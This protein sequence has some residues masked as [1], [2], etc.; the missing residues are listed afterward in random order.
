[1][2]RVTTVLSATPIKV[3]RNTS[4]NSPNHQWAEIV[5]AQTGTVL[6][7]GQIAYIRRVARKRYNRIA[8]L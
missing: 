7:R 2:R 6:H 5:H 1:M 4:A 8:E 3:R